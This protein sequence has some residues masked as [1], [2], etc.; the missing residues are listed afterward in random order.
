MFDGIKTMR[1][2]TL[3]LGPEYRGKGISHRLFELHK[4]I[5]NKVGCKQLLLEVIRENH[6][7]IAFYKKLGYLE[8]TILK[9]YTKQIEMLPALVESPPYQV[10]LVSYDM[11]KSLRDDLLTC[12]INWQN[13]T[14]HY[15]N[16]SNDIFLGAFDEYKTIGLIAVT[17]RGKINF[18][19]VD[20]KYRM[21][22]VGHYLLLEVANHIITE[23]LAVCIS[24]NPLL[25]GFFRKLDFHKEVIEQYEMYLPL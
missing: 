23:K 22:K 25:E 2:G 10:D 19:W 9:Y 6:R 4:E 11:I 21:Q 17:P 1:C 5:A 12:H 13:D 15:E 8:S 24:S 3:G 20:P 7:A 14:P 18:L 16:D